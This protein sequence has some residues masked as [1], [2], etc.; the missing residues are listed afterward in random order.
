MKL[1]DG[2]RPIRFSGSFARRA[3]GDRLQLSSRAAALVSLPPSD[4]RTAGE[5]VRKQTSR[6]LFPDSTPCQLNSAESR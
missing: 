2:P 1:Q 5:S 3:R 6:S 4:R